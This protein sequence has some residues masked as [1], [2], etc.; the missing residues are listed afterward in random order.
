[1]L[2]A[3]DVQQSP[4]LPE[5]L[6]QHISYQRQGENRVGYI[7]IDQRDSEISQATWIYVK[8]AL[9]YYRERRPDFI[10]LHL[11][12]PG[13]QVFAAQQIADALRN[14]DLVHGIPIVAYIDDWAISAGAMLALSCRFIV[15]DDHASMGAAEPVLTTGSGELMAASEKVNSA[16]RADF[17]NRARTFGRSA[18]LA[19]A[20]V[21]KDIILVWRSDAV[22]RLDSAEQIIYKGDSPDVVITSK[23]KLLTLNAQQM[24]RYGM[25]DAIVNDEIA[26]ISAGQQLASIQALRQIPFFA[27]MPDP[28]ADIYVMDWKTRFFAFLTTPAVSSALLSTLLIALYM[29]FNQPGFGI[30]GAVALTCALL[31]LLASLSLDIAGWLEIIFLLSGLLFIALEFSLLPV[32]GLL[33]A[34]GV[35]FLLGGLIGA[36]LPKIDQIHYDWNNG[37]LNA[38][39]DA[40]I[41]HLGWICA[42]IILAFVVCMLLTRY[43]ILRLSRFNPLVLSGGEQNASSGYTAAADLV[44][45]SPGSR[46]IVV[47]ALRP[48]GRVEIEGQV[49]QALSWGDFIPEGA[50]IEVMRAEGATL[51][52]RAILTEEPK[53]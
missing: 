29:E 50:N 8:K 47:G 22:V 26:Q 17:G 27:D 39:G 7:A 11:N 45:P 30:P 10:I 18:D 4:S 2:I 13:G 3:T 1:M 5:R 35:L 41:Q 28:T 52:V 6:Q 46:G 20:M 34:I 33:A 43:G 19:E 32:G 53:A 37:T 31:L 48:A 12:T 38:A 23:G 9:E 14:M 36:I 16:I 21:D 49:Y 51:F 40:F 15:V 25:A 42:G 44:L 24:L